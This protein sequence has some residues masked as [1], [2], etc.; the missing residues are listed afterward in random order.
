MKRRLFVLVAAMLATVIVCVVGWMVTSPCSGAGRCAAAAAPAM[1]L[2][3]SLLLIGGSVIA[4]LMR[5]AWLLVA[6]HRHI[7]ML[8]VGAPPSHVLT[9]AQRAG[10]EGIRYLATDAPVAFCAGGLRPAVF[11][12]AGLVDALGP[13][14]LEAVLIHE[15]EHRRRHDP[16]RRAAGRAAAEV[17]F[18][19]PLV[20]WWSE[21]QRERS[22]LGADAAVLRRLGAAP[23]ARALCRVDTVLASHSAAAFG[24]AAEIRVAQLL[25]DPLPRRTP[26][27]WT[28]PA[29]A[30]GILFMASVVLCASA[31]LGHT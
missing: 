7:W 28:W 27:A 21:R 19:I 13:D 2:T 31:V 10:V 6:A 15:G 30:V 4:W 29:S 23:L 24:G 18:Y 17:G 8:P 16:L 22:E 20:G 5:T 3:T 9:S 26:A 1:A 25:G 12:S 11:A 14:E